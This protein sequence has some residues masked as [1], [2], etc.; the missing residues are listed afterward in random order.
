M[1]GKIRIPN[2][3]PVP[4]SLKRNEHFCQ[5][6]LTSPPSTGPTVDDPVTRSMTTTYPHSTDHWRHVQLDPDNIFLPE[7]HS[8]FQSILLEYA[9]VFSPD[10]KGYNDHSGPVRAT[11]NIGPVQ[12]PQR[13]GRVPQYNRSQLVELQTKFD[14]LE[15]KGVFVR[16]E[17][18]DVTAEYLNST[19]L[20][21][22]PSG[23]TSLVT[24]LF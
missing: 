20:I 8:D 14:E 4:K 3:S 11:V 9:D 10:F 6:R 22:K 13:K 5:V 17:D 2:L 1:S 18:I 19:F 15:N 7:T 23:G 12:P 21:R 16:P 24:A